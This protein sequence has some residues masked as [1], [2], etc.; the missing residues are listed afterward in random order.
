MSFFLIY[1]RLRNAIDN[2]SAKAPIPAIRPA[3]SQS[4][5]D[6]DIYSAF[7]SVVFRYWLHSD[8]T[9]VAMA[10]R[11]NVTYTM[12]VVMT[13]GCCGVLRMQYTP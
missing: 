2:S 9:D 11:H 6:G 10:T 4:S 12:R 8:A 7:V 1:L 3:P 13:T 5:S